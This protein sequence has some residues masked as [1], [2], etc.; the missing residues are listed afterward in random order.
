VEL[1][2]L[3]AKQ[4]NVSD[5]TARRYITDAERKGEILLIEGKLF[6][7]ANV[8]NESDSLLSSSSS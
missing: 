1:A 4:R 5:A 3:L 8:D 6:P 2:A 7:A